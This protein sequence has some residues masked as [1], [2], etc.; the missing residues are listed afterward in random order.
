MRLDDQPQQPPEPHPGLLGEPA[1]DKPGSNPEHLAPCA[2]QQA[3]GLFSSIA[4]TTDRVWSSCV[5]GV[6][7]RLQRRRL[8]LLLVCQHSENF[9]MALKRL[10]LRENGPDQDH[11]KSVITLFPMVLIHNAISDGNSPSI[12]IF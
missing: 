10:I 9:G 6:R 1:L 3:A 4:C 12:P 2:A 11:C 7:R 8:A 5:G